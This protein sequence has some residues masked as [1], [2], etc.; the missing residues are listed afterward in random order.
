MQQNTM[1]EILI[2]KYILDRFYYHFYLRDINENN[3]I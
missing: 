2:M 1:S 3:N